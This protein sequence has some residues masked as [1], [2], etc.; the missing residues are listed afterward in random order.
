MFLGPREGPAVSLASHHCLDLLSARRI[1]TPPGTS[2]DRATEAPVCTSQDSIL[3]VICCLHLHRLAQFG[4]G[5]QGGGKKP[6]SGSEQW[7]LQATWPPG[8]HRRDQAR[9]ASQAFGRNSLAKAAAAEGPEVC[10]GKGMGMRTRAH[11]PQHQRLCH[12]QSRGASTPS[13]GPSWRVPRSC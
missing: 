9:E 8:A 3:S 4:G 11:E 10:P 12:P 13:G 5:G 6:R 7:G 2:A 1:A